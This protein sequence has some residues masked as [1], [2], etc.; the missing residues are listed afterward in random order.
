MNHA[1]SLSIDG[2][3]SEGWWWR[4][5]WWSL[6]SCGDFFFSDNGVNGRVTRAEGDSGRHVSVFQEQ[7][8]GIL[9]NLMSFFKAWV[10]TLNWAKKDGWRN[11]YWIGKSLIYY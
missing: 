4:W 11:T 1:A 9:C 8:M 3:G 10:A 6:C 2:S 7:K 5:Q